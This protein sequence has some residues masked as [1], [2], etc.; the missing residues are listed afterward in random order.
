MIFELYSSSRTTDRHAE[1][2][3]SQTTTR[4]LT[5]ETFMWQFL[6][7]MG[8]RGPKGERGDKGERGEIGKIP[9]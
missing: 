4:T 3:L 1:E 9:S 2:L 7:P 6:G 5:Y 8:E